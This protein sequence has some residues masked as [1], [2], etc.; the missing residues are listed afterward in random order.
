MAGRLAPLLLLIAVAGCDSGAAAPDWGQWGRDAAHTGRSPALGQPLGRVL[1]D[2]LYDP[3][4]EAVASSTGAVYI[5]YPA[6][7][8]SGDDVYMTFKTG[9][10][11]QPV[12]TQKG[13]SLVGGEARERW[14]Y[15][16]DWQP[17]PGL[18]W[19]PVFH[20]ALS[21]R[22]LYVPAAG[23]AVDRVDRETG[24]RLARI[25][26]FG[27]ARDTFV[28]GPITLVPGGSL[29]YN[30]LAVD[31]ADP[32]RR[33][34]RGGWLVRIGPGDRASAASYASLVGSAPAAGAD[35]EQAFGAAQLPW[36]P[37]PDARP[38]TAPC[39]SQR[40]GVNVAPAVSPD[41][42]VVTVSRA[43]LNDRYGY[44]VALDADLTPRWAASLRDRLSDGCGSALLPPSGMPGGCRAGARPGV[45]PATNAA[46]A[47][48][49][50]DLSSASPVVAPDGS[51][52]YAAFTR[53]NGARGHL[54][55]FDASGV[56]LAAWDYGWDVT[57][58]IHTHRGSWSVVVKDN[59][60]GG[61]SYCD[62]ARYCPPGPAGPY[63][64]AQLSPDL[65][66]EWRSEPA[67]DEWCISAPAVD[68][69]GT[70][71]AV[72]EDGHLY[73]V[74]QGGAV[75]DRILLARAIGAAY[76][77]LAIGGD[78]RIFALNYGRLFVVG[79]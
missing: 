52:L 39:G 20:P 27:G 48:R 35:C 60:Y 19:E 55:R 4:A 63:R 18:A 43:H 13:L 8:V 66:P 38:R 12:W 76:T 68:A 70:V 21:A 2:L 74:R 7:L 5:H 61:G 29:L 17:V 51:V 65:E 62:D 32:W 71:F 25:D 30:A 78:G 3:F 37:A 40:P 42:G 53:Y 36:P 59:D 24:A 77:P 14:T 41:G 67:P 15:V 23:G 34:A 44:V 11:E 9:S 6:P 49:V 79:R 28:V 16:S 45:D 69:D 47:G 54:F 58:A 31:P 22:H 10:P 46:P 33:D 73:A 50:V 64:L 26:P 75:R 72:N 1:A 56:F 57:P